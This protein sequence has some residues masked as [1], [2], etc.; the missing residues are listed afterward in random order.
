MP[1]PTVFVPAL[2][3]RELRQITQAVR[4]SHNPKMRDRCRAVL[5]SA[6][7][8]TTGEIA[9]LL[10]V[11]MTTPMRWIKDYLRFGFDGL[12]PESSTGRSRTVDADAQ[13]VLRQALGKIPAIWGTALPAG[14]SPLWGSI[15]AQFFIFRYHPLR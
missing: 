15:C 5:W 3:A 13:E 6:E 4:S 12:V 8:K 10:A 9:R 14:R 2:S 11:N 1:A 7:G